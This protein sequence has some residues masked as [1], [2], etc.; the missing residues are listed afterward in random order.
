MIDEYY[1]WLET[2]GDGRKLE[3]IKYWFLLGKIDN[4]YRYYK[5]DVINEE[6]DMINYPNFDNDVDYVPMAK[7][8]YIRHSDASTGTR[9]KSGSVELDSP[10]NHPLQVSYRNQISPVFLDPP[11]D[12]SPIS[13]SEKWSHPDF[14]RP[15]SALLQ[16]TVSYVFFFFFFFCTYKPIVR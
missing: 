6:E 10:N 12:S 9:S 3:F 15:S 7:S 1:E 5:D 13:G 4:D 14:A 2:G 8:N 11:S 16:P